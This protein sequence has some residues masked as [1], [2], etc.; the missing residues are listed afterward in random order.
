[1][2]Q[3]FKTRFRNKPAGK[4][5]NRRVAFSNVRLF[6]SEKQMHSDALLRRAYVNGSEAAVTELV[7]RYADLVHS[8]ALRQVGERELARDVAQQVFIDLARKA[9]RLSDSVVLAGWLYRGTHFV[10]LSTL[11]Q[12]RRRKAREQEAM[13]C[14]KTE[15]EP[16]VGWDRIGPVLDEAVNALS[17]KDRDAVLL[18]FFRNEDLHAR[19]S[20]AASVTTLNLFHLMASTKIKVAAS[21]LTPPRRSHPGS[22]NSAQ[23]RNC[24]PK[25]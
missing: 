1:L 25:I 12:G 10:A 15:P 21:S 24:G 18:R 14:S 11:C 16:V 6:I 3:C 9:G 8:A 4:S 2:E 5:T 20:A 13:S 19:V 23:S 7:G 22:G 17:A